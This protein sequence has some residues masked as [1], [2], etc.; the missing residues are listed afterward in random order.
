MLNRVPIIIRRGLFVV[1]GF[2]AL[3]LSAQ[4]L[5]VLGL[6]NPVVVQGSSMAPTL[7]GRRWVLDCPR[8]GRTATIGID[9]RLAAPPPECLICSHPLADDAVRLVGADRLWIDRAPGRLR[10]WDLVVFRCPYDAQTYCIKR[11]VGLPGETVSLDA[12]DVLINGGRAT[13]PLATQLRVRRLEHTPS[14]TLPGWAATSGNW[15]LQQNAWRGIAEDGRIAELRYLAPVHDDL[16][17]NVGVSRRFNPLSDL[18]VEADVEQAA[19]ARWQIQLPGGHATL[20]AGRGT[21]SLSNGAREE[22]VDL[23]APLRRVLFSNFDR[24]LLA[25]VNGE[26][27]LRLPVVDARMNPRPVVRVLEASVELGGLSLYKDLFYEGTPLAFG[28]AG[29]QPWRIGP[30]EYF[31][32]GDNQAVS[33]DSRR[34][35]SGPGLPRR[36][37]VG[38]PHRW[39]Q[40]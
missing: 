6:A 38:R 27:V 35:D 29:D 1:V 11:V 8:C 36:L 3:L 18:M 31:V 26:A 5:V 39:R 25:A 20:D 21:L 33:V 13:K 19:N 14:E 2:V 12:G 34:W 37:I 9:Q 16:P 28:A 24:T 17:G 22:L 4:T 23:P 40:Q 32:L 7:E 15:R 30:G 10:R